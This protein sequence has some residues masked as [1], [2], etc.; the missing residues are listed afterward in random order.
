MIINQG[1][2]MMNQ[3]YKDIKQIASIL[4]RITTSEDNTIQILANEIQTILTYNNK[5]KHS[6]IHVYLWHNSDKE[7]RTM[8]DNISKTIASFNNWVE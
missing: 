1:R 5:S 3:D 6:I 4:E 2:Y 8:G 7:V